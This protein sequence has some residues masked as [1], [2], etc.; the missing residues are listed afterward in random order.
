SAACGFFGATDNF[1]EEGELRTGRIRYGVLDTKV[2]N[3]V[4]WRTAPISGEIMVEA[5]FD[6][7][8]VTHVGDQTEP[9][10]VGGTGHMGPV[11][12]EWAE[13][14]F[15]LMRC[16]EITP[17]LFFNGS[18][19]DATTPDHANFV[20]TD[21]DM[22]WS[23]ALENWVPGG[24][25]NKILMGQTGII[26]DIG[27]GVFINSDGR[28]GVT[29]SPDG[30]LANS[31]T[32]MTTSPPELGLGSE[33]TIA[34]TLDV[35]NGAG[36]RTYNFMV[37]GALFE[38]ITVGATTSIFNSTQLLRVG[39]LSTLSPGSGSYCTSAI[40]RAS[41]GGAEVANPDFTI[42]A[43]GAASFADTAGTPKTWTVAAPA[44]I[45]LI[46]E[47]EDLTPRLRWW[48]LRAI[49]GTEE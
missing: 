1:V 19:G 40:L 22:Q 14:I 23:G 7:G 27:W 35:N 25:G 47:A 38:T 10:T 32:Q 16:G 13:L 37:D 44:T 15:H 28:I 3:D 30:T 49:P 36:G 42:Q 45:A 18:G 41:I 26:A 43:V 9:D 6:D 5:E 17:A 8:N 29:T 20:I 48:I 12:A 4:S 11:F 24:S 31:I 34:L 2:F 33:H 21:L 39:H 46:N